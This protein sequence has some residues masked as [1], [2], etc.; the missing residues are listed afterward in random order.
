[1]PQNRDREYIYQVK[2]RW[3]TSAIFLVKLVMGETLDK[4]GDNDIS[5]GYRLVN[6]YLKDRN[7]EDFKTDTLL[8]L[9]KPDNWAEFDM[10]LEKQESHKNFIEEYDYDK[11]YVVL[12]YKIPLI[13]KKDFLKFKDGKYSEFSKGSKQEF[14]RMIPSGIFGGGKVKSLQ[15]EIFE[16][17]QDLKEQLEN[18]LDVQ[19]PEGSEV[20]SVPNLQNEILNIDL[21]YEQSNKNSPTKAESA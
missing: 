21:I 13:L 6:T 2:K 20:W 10:F 14:N 11:G 19:L 1:M 16:K 15:W 12:A 3:N 8:L 7:R 18:D 17:E 9:F 5:E 4:L